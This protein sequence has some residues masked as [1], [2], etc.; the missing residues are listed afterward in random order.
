[1]EALSISVNTRTNT[2]VKKIICIILSI[3]V[4]VVIMILALIALH[5]VPFGDEHSLAITDAKYYLNGEMWFSRLLKG[6]E[7]ILYS[8]NN[9]LG[10]NEWSV[11]AWGGFSFG[12]LLSYFATL[13]TIPSVF[14]WIC[15]VNLA[16]CGLTMYLLLAYMN[17]HKASNLIFSTSYAL[18]GFNVVNCYQTGFF[19]GPELL[20]LVIL[21]LFLLFRGKNP[22]LYILSF[23]FCTFFNFY[24]AFHLG[25]ISLIFMIGYLCVHKKNLIGKRLKLFWKWLLASVIGGLLAAPMWLPTLKAYSGGGRLDQTGLTEYTFNENM[26]F[27]QMFSKLF[28][29]ANSTNELVTGMPNIFCGIL[30]LALVILYFINK[31]IDIRKKRAAGIILG[32]YLISFYIQA[33]TLVMHGGT[34]TNWFPYRYSYVFSFLLICLAVEEFRY[35]GEIT[36]KEIKKCGIV[37]LISALVVFGTS[38]EFI[39]GGMV[40][41][42]FVL[43]LLMLL[44]FWFYKT[45][46]DKAPLRTFSMLLLILVSINLYANFIV[47]TKS[48]QEW[49]LDLKQ[50]N[51]NIMT[52]GAL[53]GALNKAEKEFFRMEKDYSESASV[54]SDPLLYD[55]NGVSHSGPAERMFIHQ[56]L[57]KLGINWYD[58]RHWYLEGIPAATDC[59]LGLKYL[60]SEQD[61]A[62]EKGY[63]AIIEMN[64]KTIYKNPHALSACILANKDYSDLVLEDNMFENMNNAWK[65][66]TGESRDIFT[67]QEDVTFSLFSDYSNQSVT[68]KELKESI[69]VTDEKVSENS[70]EV[71]KESADDEQ[72]KASYIAYTFEASQDGPIY[73]FDTSIP[74]S[75][76]GLAGPSIKYVGYYQKGD[77]V[78]G[79]FPIYEGIGTGDLLRGFCANQVFAYADNNV[80]AD[81]AAK[82]NA[83]DISFEV[84]KETNPK[85]TFTA[86]EKQKILFTM[87]WDEG[88][89]CFID[90]QQVP[91]EKT[92]DLFMSVDAPAGSHTWELRFFPAW[93][94]YGL[95]LCGIAFAGL[96]IFMII[97]NREKKKNAL[98]A[99]A[100]GTVR[101]V[102]DNTNVDS[103]AMEDSTAEEKNDKDTSEITDNTEPVKKSGDE[104]NPDSEASQENTAKEEDKS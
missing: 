88:W 54:A 86:G 4:P 94:N 35:I 22:L 97:W 27:I 23:G 14:T 42:D 41:L 19:L 44:G 87:P 65:K 29:G 20:P 84:E 5:I 47:S 75:P 21:G 63:E 24:F 78:E 79:K 74:G 50:Y 25:V 72:K 37:L 39:S 43:L 13:E 92:W 36:F 67:E 55:Y 60:I 68:S 30:V 33:F 38:Y 61:L 62:E 31:R 90:G 59:L 11:F 57:N 28:S 48:V 56:E 101:I 3:L 85:G 69:S 93:M 17:G 45:R 34:H 66:M 73:V 80:L 8:C 32:I 7:N 15:V 102:E 89:S 40:L 91:I 53:I 96:I 98:V 77:I 103:V 100:D 9:G 26:P 49:E 104:I 82:L 70:A 51:E 95:I 18:I 71:S 12:N 6:Q 46:P 52:S 81:Y 16:I 99:A 2:T 58:M 1:M 76:N 83:R 64:G 10:G